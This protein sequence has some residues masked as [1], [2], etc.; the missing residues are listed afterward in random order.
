MV[1]ILLEF[2][3]NDCSV[4][5]TL[6]ELI[7]PK[8]VMFFDKKWR[9]V[10]TRSDF[11]SE[12]AQVTNI[13]VS[14]LNKGRE[15]KVYHPNL[16]RFSI[17]SRM[18]WAAN[19]QTTRPEDI[20][21]CLFGI[22]GIHLPPLYGEGTT[23]AFIRLQHEIMKASMDLS[24]LAWPGDRREFPSSFVLADSPNMFKH[25]MGIEFDQNGDGEPFKMT[26]KGLRVKTPLIIN[27][28]EERT[29]TAVLQSCRYSN[30]S[31]TWIGLRL[32]R[33]PY[34]TSPPGEG[35]SVWYRD[36][37]LRH[38]VPTVYSVDKETVKNAKIYKIYLLI[39]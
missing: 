36:V 9:F 1:H 14:L 8:L 19:R 10:G 23:K 24:I 11:S 4:N 7:A 12:L 16:E 38:E 33:S 28:G 26:N 25:V 31:A 21:Y 32:R 35:R 27:D 37:R 22:F 2:L 13:D 18:S 17:A 5:R 30:R 29:C 15:R 39:Q 6:Q 3:A 20:A 34:S